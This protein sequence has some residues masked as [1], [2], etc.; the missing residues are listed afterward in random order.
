MI[1]LQDDGSKFLEEDTFH[2]IQVNRHRK[3][4]C[5]KDWEGGG[6]EGRRRRRCTLSMLYT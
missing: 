1:A 3:N 4:M 6:G 5:A 2:V